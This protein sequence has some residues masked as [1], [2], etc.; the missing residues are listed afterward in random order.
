MGGGGSGGGAVVM[1]EHSVVVIEG[2]RKVESRSALPAVCV[3]MHAWVP[4]DPKVSGSIQFACIR[5][6]AVFGAIRLEQG[7]AL[8]K[9]FLDNIANGT[10]TVIISALL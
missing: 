7:G 8:P 3:P 10:L 9:D 5:H 1:K 6:G 4:I 2:E